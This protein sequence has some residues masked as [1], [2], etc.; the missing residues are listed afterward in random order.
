MYSF[1]LASY[2]VRTWPPN[3][4]SLAA[5]V[6]LAASGALLAYLSKCGWFSKL[7]LTE[8]TFGPYL[9]LHV[10]A[11]ASLPMLEHHIQCEAGCSAMET[12]GMCCACYGMLR[13]TRAHAM[14]HVQG[15]YKTAYQHCKELRR[16]V[17]EEARLDCEAEYNKRTAV[18]IYFDDPSCT[19]ASNCRFSMAVVQDTHGSTGM[20]ST[21]P[22][23]LSH[24]VQRT[25]QRLLLAPPAQTQMAM[26]SPCNLS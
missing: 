16:L 13:V 12:F 2:S 14:D 26:L 19:P 20:Q 23:E 9:L 6:C 25:H 18:G 22:L 10:N 24:S 1:S 15:P 3:M 5:G 21:V 4:A 8:E 17:I 7:V 11:Q